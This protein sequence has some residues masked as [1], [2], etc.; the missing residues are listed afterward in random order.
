MR[1]AGN[2]LVLFLVAVS[3]GIAPARADEAKPEQVEFFEKKIRPVLAKNCY[4]CHSSATAAPMGGLRVDTRDALLRGGKGGPAVKPGDLSGSSLWQAITYEHSIKMPP[5]GKLPPEQVADLRT[6]IEQGAAGP[7]DET[8]PKRSGLDLAQGKRFWS[9]QPIS[10]PPVPSVKASGWVHSPIDAFILSKLEAAGLQPAPPAGKRTL[11]RRVTYDLIGLPPT[12][13]EVRAFLSDESPDAF[14]RV[15]DRLLAS[16]Q[17]GERWARHWL[18]LVRYAETNGHEFDNDKLD[19]WRYRDYVIRAFNEDLP[20]NQ[21]VREH[22]AG[23]LLEQKRLSEDRGAWESPIAT[24]FFWFGEVL[25]SATDSVKSRAD[26]VDNQIDVT[27]KA[28]LG[29][30]VACARCHDHKFDPIPTA[31]YYSLAGVLHSTDIRETVNDSPERARKIHALAKQI[32]EINLELGRQP[33]Y[34]RAQVTLRPGDLR[35]DA[36]QDGSF[37]GWSTSGAAFGSAP[38]GALASSFAA[39]SDKFVGTLTSPKFRTGKQ[40]YL[41][42][43]LAGTKVDGALKERTPLRFTL[44]ADGYKSQHIVPEGNSAPRWKTVRLT[45]ERER[46]CYFEIVDRSREGY[47][48]I[49]EIVFSDSKEPPATEE[50]AEAAVPPATD[51]SNPQLARRAQLEGQIPE[52][53]FAMTAAD[54]QPHDVKIHLRGS[55]TNLGKI[56]PRQFLQVI[57]GE[58]QPKVEEGSGRKYIADWLTNPENPLTARVMVNRIWKHHFKQ[59]IVRSPDNFGV[60]GERPTHPE[61]L[62]YL[63]TQFEQSGW[64]VKAMH[65]LMLLSSAYQMSSEPDQE[66]AKFDPTNKLLQ[67]APV[68]RLEAEAIRDAILAVSGSL[69]T[70]LFGPSVPPHISKYQDGRGK[71]VSGP[72]DGN[73][74]RSIYVQ[75]RRN[76]L[77]PLMLSFDY[78]LPISTIGARGTSTVPSQALLLMNNEFVAAQAE[79]WAKHSMTAA[80][81]IPERVEA[82]YETAFSRAPQPEEVR[83]IDA[84][85]GSQSAAYEKAKV[86]NADNLQLQVWTDVAHVLLNSPEFIYLR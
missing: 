39:G 56:A 78:P 52:S 23:D 30:T 20:Y 86:G 32:R 10:N 68:Q 85:V 43:R 17:Y 42:V 83:S 50:P 81:T 71:P 26:E 65:R 63:A 5:S 12:P 11:L 47:I 82:M 33:V 60:M 16:P 45:L 44:V 48:A 7:R 55:H 35:F 38:D 4:A 62:D 25:N 1:C 73:G 66:A 29:L 64:S 51:V 31:D 54:Y 13:A 40:L 59:G 2:T 53:S 84:F 77:S 67:H 36:F 46:N 28:F 61:L 24:S 27:G 22:I 79:L 75:V 74:R 3:C 76:F 70:R 9:F 49:G 15:V 72:L 37:G 19:A 69:D 80:T 6:W 34:P 8:N 18:D 21:F 57:A 14:R 41:H 58:D